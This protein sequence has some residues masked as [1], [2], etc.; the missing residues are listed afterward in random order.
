MSCACAALQVTVPR[1]NASLSRTTGRPF[2]FPPKNQVHE[3]GGV[4]GPVRSGLGGCTCMTRTSL[5]LKAPKTFLYGLEAPPE[6]CLAE[7]CV[8]CDGMKR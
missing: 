1:P 2:P 8:H 6:R 5:K 3:L 7:V 4:G